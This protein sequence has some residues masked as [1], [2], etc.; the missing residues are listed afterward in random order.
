[1][2]GVVL[3]DTAVLEHHDS[4]GQVAQY[5]KTVGNQQDAAASHQADD[6]LQQLPLGERV[7]TF[8][9][10]VQDQDGRVEQQRSR[11][12][13]PPCLAAGQAGTGFSEFGVVPGRLSGNEVM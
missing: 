8:G 12:G 13:Q 7:E 10:F 5:R 9:G 6:G 1:M 2:C 11:D 3:H 4:V